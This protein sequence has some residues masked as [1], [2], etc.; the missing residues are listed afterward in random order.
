MIRVL[1]ADDHDIVR[2]GLRLLLQGQPDITVIGEAADGQEALDL[3]TQL[4]PDILLIDIT[5]PQ[6]NG[7]EV[8]QRVRALG[9]PIRMLVVSMHIDRAIV[10]AA[11]QSGAMGYLV[12]SSVGQDLV[13]AICAVHRGEAY[14]ATK[15]A[16]ALVEEMFELTR[17]LPAADSLSRLTGREREVL[18]LLVVGHTNK[19]MAQVMHISPRTVEKFRTSLMEKLNASDLATLIQTAFQKGLISNKM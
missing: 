11:L 2:V 5:M 15:A 6:I 12:K 13:P 3:A 9:L 1:I 10:H 17:P 14:L 4:V 7:N 8:I 18:Q 19:T 16:S